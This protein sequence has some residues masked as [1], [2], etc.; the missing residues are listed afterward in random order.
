MSSAKPISSIFPLFMT[1]SLDPY[2][3]KLRIENLER[4]FGQGIFED[5]V[6]LDTGA[7]KDEALAPY[8]DTGLYWLE[9]KT[10]NAVLGADLGLKSIMVNHVHNSDCKDERIAKVDNWAQISDLILA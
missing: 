6:C 5:V 9:D 1:L 8:K 7:D 2:A 4:V 3:K 10:E